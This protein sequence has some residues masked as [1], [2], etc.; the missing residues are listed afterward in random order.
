M[1][2]NFVKDVTGLLMIGMRMHKEQTFSQ[3][4]I[5]DSFADS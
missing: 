2:T 3:F 1:K 5:M 4:F